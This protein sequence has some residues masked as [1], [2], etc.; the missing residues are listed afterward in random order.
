[1][2]LACLEEVAR[3]AEG[4]ETAASLDWCEDLE[5]IFIFIPKSGRVRYKI[6]YFYHL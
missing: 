3:I 5:V 4:S 6:V 2:A 1:M